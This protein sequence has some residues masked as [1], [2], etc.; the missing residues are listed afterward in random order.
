MFNT[1]RT[2]PWQKESSV[3]PLTAA[4]RRLQ[5][6]AMQLFAERGV[7]RITVS[8]L[9]QAA[10]IARGTI[11]NNLQDVDSLFPE[12]ATQLADEMIDLTASA[13]ASLDDPAQRLANGIRYFVKRAHEDPLW[14]RFVCRFA[15]ST[16]SLQKMWAG[17]PVKDLHE[18]L[19]KGRYAFKREQL[20]SAVSLVAGAI[21]GSMTLVLD[22][23]KTWRDAGS[24]A[25]EFVLAA[26]GVPR[27]EAR[28]LASMDLPGAAL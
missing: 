20:A 1:M 23:R 10:G 27:E 2:F 24:D 13:S 3:L 17:Q 22:G 21:L 7:T 25:A 12:V 5:R 14:G 19:D 11:Y 6:V 16:E 8:E 15:L 26:I 4:Q 18:G 9:A 28:M